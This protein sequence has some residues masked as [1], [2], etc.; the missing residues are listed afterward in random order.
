MLNIPSEFGRQTVGFVTVTQGDEPGY[1]GVTTEQRSAV[2]MSGVRFRPFKT[3]ELAGLT[4]ELKGLT[5]ISGE[6]WKLTAPVG[7]ASLAAE[8]TG[9]VIYDGTDTPTLDDDDKSN[10]FH[11][12]GFKQPKP[13]MYGVTHHV[14]I[15][16][17]RQDA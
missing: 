16:C 7:A 9:E 15:V 2:L 8:S 4:S 11:I 14:T 10:R 12:E 5:N 3:E 17:Q 13:D 6:L 1:L